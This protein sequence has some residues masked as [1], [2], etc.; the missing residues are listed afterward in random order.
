MRNIETPEELE[1]VEGF[2]RKVVAEGESIYS[3]DC[4]ETEISEGEEYWEHSSLE[5][6]CS[7]V[8]AR[9][10]YYYL[11]GLAEHPHKI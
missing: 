6:F 9:Q 2:E 1:K 5:I 8:S 10:Y 7:F 4:S 3:T 11:Q